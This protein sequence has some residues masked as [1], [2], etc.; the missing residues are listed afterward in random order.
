M[1]LLSLSLAMWLLESN[2]LIHELFI[3]FVS[4]SFFLFYLVKSLRLFSG[5]FDQ[6]LIII[7]NNNHYKPQFYYIIL[8]R[9]SVNEE[10][11]YKTVMIKQAIIKS[12]WKQNSNVRDGWKR[13]GSINSSALLK[14]IEQYSALFRTIT[15]WFKLTDIQHTQICRQTI[16]HRVT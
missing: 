7:I 1:F 10:L 14:V 13:R 5:R 11:S 15:D 6:I 12:I 3:L 8:K 2:N 9:S 4:L 16:V